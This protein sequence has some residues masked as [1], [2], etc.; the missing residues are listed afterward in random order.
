MTLLKLCWITL[1]TLLL[2]QAPGLAAAPADDAF[3]AIRDAAKRDDLKR[4]EQLLPQIQGYVLE[5]Y[6]QYWRMRARLEMR[7]PEE[8]RAWLQAQANTPLAD[9]LRRDWLRVLARTAQWGVFA[10][11]WPA[12]QTEDI[13]LSC[14]ALQVRQRT[15]SAAALEARPLWFVGRDQPASCEAIFQSLI[16]KGQIT[17]EDVW[18]RVRL[19]LDAG[20]V[21]VAQRVAQFLPKDSGL[22]LRTL[23]HIYA[24]PTPFL[25]DP[26][27]DLK[28][29]GG[30][31]SLIFAVSR[32]ARTAPAQAAAFW[33]KWAPSCSVEE[34]Q[35][36]WGMIA[37]YGARRHDALALEWFS[38]AGVLTDAQLAWRVRAALRQQRW[39]EVLAAV[40]AMSVKYATD[41]TWRYWRARALKALDRG[42]E[43]QAIF[44]AL[45][46]D[47]TFYGQLAL[48][49]V[50]GT[51]QIPP[52]TFKP[53]EQDLRNMGARPAIQRAL[54]LNR[55][56]MRAEALRE[57]IL[58][59]RQAGDR[60]LLTA[61]E[62]AWQAGMYDRAINTADRT[63]LEHD[64]GLRYMSPFRDQLRAAVRRH[65]LDEAWVS[66]LIRQESRFIAQAQSRVGASGLMQLMPTTARWVAQKL[67]LKGWQWSQ[68][69]D[70]ETNL[71]FGSFYLRHVYNGLDSSP[72]LA[73]AAYNAG[74]G[75]A[76]VW[77]G[78]QRMEAAIYAESIPF[79]ETRDYV[80]KVM[81]NATYYAHLQGVTQ[82]L[83]ARI[84]YI[85]PRSAERDKA[86]ADTP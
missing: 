29:R 14:Y 27:V 83:R 85:Q 60:D 70:I 11:E 21:N 10:A 67:G 47:Y 23:A 73:T 52:V 59:M 62:L 68:I 38:R 53:S 13:E 49:E 24:N 46:T 66:S 51:V 9:Q 8:I 18:T 39:P 43:A 42:A 25:Q 84:G 1:C 31:E 5:P 4:I 61:A 7:P 50:G 63:G 36:A 34:R 17:P 28:T 44:K 26:R 45:A 12:L 41:M 57:W 58:A 56:E 48:E 15:E 19:A 65:D 77:R 86:L 79:E 55:L 76:Q 69:T 32:L 74:P 82:T 54:A 16:D 35:Y 40:D 30:R 20:Q 37:F 71:N 80:K 3:L 75:R 78:E 64:F 33:E 2:T 72:V 6:A 22:E 81:G